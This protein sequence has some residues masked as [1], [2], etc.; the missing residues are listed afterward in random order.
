M[1]NSKAPKNTKTKPKKHVVLIVLAVVL[2]AGL[3]L[4][5]AR[6]WLRMT[7]LPK[8]VHVT[9]G[10]SVEQTYKDEIGKLQDPLTK[11]GYKNV[12]AAKGTCT[13]DLARRFKTQ[14]Y[15]TY[16]VS[17]S[18]PVDTS[19]QNKQQLSTNVAALLALLKSNG[20]QGDFA[21]SGSESSNNLSTLV[22]NIASNID[23]NPDA[24]YQ[25]QIGDI[26]CT[27]GN[28][29][30]FAKPEPPALATQISCSRYFNV[31]GEPQ[32]SN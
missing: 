10:S 19:Q 20:W 6:G 22:S 25:K 1:P 5:V 21:T 32:W 29:T 31:L 3:L 12:E 24:T 9:V 28:N 26:T 15:C 16:G 4:F 30:A 13:T 17:V 8:I 23:Y 14:V 11:L 2:G 18:G 7:V 27:F